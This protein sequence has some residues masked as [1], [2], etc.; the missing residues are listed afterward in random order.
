MPADWVGTYRLQL[1][2]GFDLRDA[3]SV[4]PYLADLGVSHVYLSPCLQA[5]PGSLHGYDVTDPTRVSDDLGG[6]QAW[7]RFV[8]R[9]RA[10][11]LSIL[12]DIVPN[13]MAAS[14][15]DLWWD[16]VLEHGP[17]AEHAAFF[18]I[19]T[20]PGEPWRVHLCT[21]AHPYGQTLASDELGL[22]LREGRP[23]L[24]YFEAS[25]PLGPASWR[26]L[27]EEA[28]WYAD[29]PAVEACRE[30]ERL[31]ALELA[32][33]AVTEAARHRYR[34]AL[35]L[36]RTALA[37]AAEAGRLSGSLERVRADA[38]RLDALLRRQFYVLHHWKL[39]GELTNY[40]R[41][42]DVSGLVGVRNELEE[43]FRA[44]HARI[45]DMVSD[46]DI[47]GLRIDH[48]DGL[49]D[50]GRYFEILRERLPH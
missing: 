43:V 10:S 37:R 17:Y 9:T 15:Y 36:A 5:T 3:E 50:P 24:T 21:L 18:D 34:M 26:L 40:R 49:R 25:F 28:G 29:D 23:R 19:R 30:L 42:F 33:G 1:H 2:A 47:D 4:L 6:E 41:F 27:L 39:A 22:E 12:L 45:L 31:Q 8:E 44:S 32:P 13:H 35:P 46:G 16:E 14:Q 20:Q 38:Q 48:P 7:R 11:G